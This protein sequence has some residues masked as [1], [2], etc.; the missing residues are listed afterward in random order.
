[1]RKTVTEQMADLLANG[2]LLTPQA[3]AAAL[4]VLT[5]HADGAEAARFLLRIDRRFVEQD[6]MY[7]CVGQIESPDG[8]IV[9]AAGRYFQE[10]GKRGELLEHLAPHI[11]QETGATPQEIAEALRRYYVTT[12]AGR[13]VLAR[14]KRNSGKEEG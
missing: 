2:R 7:R 4:P 12:A 10:L 9:A 6:G 1:M 3:I 5:D 8:R 11:E 14:R 13:M